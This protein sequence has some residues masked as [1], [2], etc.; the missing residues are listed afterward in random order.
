M[1]SMLQQERA[2]AL[3]LVV[4]A[5]LAEYRGFCEALLPKSGAGEQGGE[6]LKQPGAPVVPIL[7]DR[8][9]P[10]CRT[11]SIQF[12]ANGLLQDLEHRVDQ[13]G[14]RPRADILTVAFPQQADVAGARYGVEV[15]LTGTDLPQL[16]QLCDLVTAVHLGLGGEPAILGFTPGARD[17]RGGVGRELTN[18]LEQQCGWRR[19]RDGQRGGCGRHGLALRSSG[20]RCVTWKVARAIKQ[21]FRRPRGADRATVTPMCD[22][23]DA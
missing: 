10:S 23:P 3:D 16:E 1:T 14:D 20:R 15:D 17:R 5:I 13:R 22:E 9:F 12:R 4:D 19:R 6:Q 21:D 2:E 7:S 11:A 8:S 18:L